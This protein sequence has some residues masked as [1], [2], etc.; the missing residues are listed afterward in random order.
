VNG[1]PNRASDADITTI[2]NPKPRII[3]KNIIFK[4]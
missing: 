1:I 3:N 2:T 4:I